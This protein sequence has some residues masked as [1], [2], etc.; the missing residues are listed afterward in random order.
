MPLVVFSPLFDISHKEGLDEDRIKTF[1]GNQIDNMFLEQLCKEHGEFDIIVDDG[2]HVPFHVIHTFKELFPRLKDGGIYVVEDTQ[3]SYWKSM[4]GDYKNP[5]NLTTSMNY[6]KNLADGLNFREFVE[7]GYTPTYFDLNITSIHFYH[8][9]IFI[10][11][12]DN[13]EQSN[14]IKNNTGNDW[15]F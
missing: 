5:A 4:G 15:A 7:P 6:F 9:L 11:K 10:Y 1:Q 14:V 3:T 8:N 12:G 2:R 13:S